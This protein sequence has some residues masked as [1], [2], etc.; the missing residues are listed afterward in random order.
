MNPAII[1]TERP[2][3]IPYDYLVTSSALAA[4]ASQTVPLLL[5]Q[6]WWFEPV[7]ILASSSLDT[8]TDI[9][10]NNFSVQIQDIASGRFMSSA[11]VP[12]R[13]ATPYNQFYTFRRR[14]YF[15]PLTNL[16][17][18]FLNL[19]GSSNTVSLVLNG[20]K[21]RQMPDQ[22]LT[23]EQALPFTYIVTSQA[24]SANG[25]GLS[26]LTL[27]QDSF[28]E[29]HQI[30]GTCTA[31]ATADVQPNNFSFRY[32]DTAGD[33]YASARIP[34]R[35]IVQFNKEVSLRNMIQFRPGANLSFDFLD[36]SGG[37]NTVTLALKGYKLFP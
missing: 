4:N 17:F 3:I 21:C 24:L 26:T 10:P 31:D 27:Q 29:L 30:V 36:L 14:M 13:L 7:Q 16:F 32:Q 2:A 9:Q 6:D 19:T 11:R 22:S 8:D 1:S 35:A 23:N 28:F 15:P 37:T 25:S 33:F 12:Q 18:D 34:Q 20:F 5:D